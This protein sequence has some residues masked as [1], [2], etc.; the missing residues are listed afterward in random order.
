MKLNVSVLSEDALDKFCE[1]TNVIGPNGEIQL[2]ATPVAD[3][4]LLL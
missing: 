2:A 1:K 4:I 3:L